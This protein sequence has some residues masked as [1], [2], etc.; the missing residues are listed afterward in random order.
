[1]SE[2]IQEREEW[3]TE[4]LQRDF[5]VRGFGGGLCVVVRRS[6]GQLGSL[7]FDHMPR[8]YYGF[9]AHERSA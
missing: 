6:D 8:V 1:M 2:Q 7:K 9:V 3:D 4:A 5:E